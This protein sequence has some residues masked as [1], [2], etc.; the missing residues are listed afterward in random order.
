MARLTYEEQW[1]IA[2]FPGAVGN[3]TIASDATRDYN[4]FAYA[5]HETH[6]RWA[7]FP[8][9]QNDYWPPLA[10]R[11]ISIAA[12]MVAFETRGFRECVDGS[13]EQGYEKIALY[14]N[15]LGASHAARLLPSGR[16]GSKLG[17]GCD[18]EHDN[19]E[20]LAEYGQVRAF[21]KRPH[22]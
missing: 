1:V 19:L 14:H 11:D 18:I 21:M 7:P 20:D 17:D 5:A 8:D 9:R 15:G 12:L 10:P 2:R 4:C 13:A 6:R 3:F 16:W 22:P